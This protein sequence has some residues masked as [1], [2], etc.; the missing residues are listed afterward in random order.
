MGTQGGTRVP[1][2]DHLVRALLGCRKREIVPISWFILS[3]FQITS[4]SPENL[5][6]VMS[7]GRW[8]TPWTP[9]TPFVA[10]PPPPPPADQKTQRCE[11]EFQMLFNEKL[12]GFCWF[13]S[14][15]TISVEGDA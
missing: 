6:L 3:D 8:L 2:Y 9:T 5:T 10:D 7:G 15:I 12:D 13:L 11:N 4:D 14:F 1:C